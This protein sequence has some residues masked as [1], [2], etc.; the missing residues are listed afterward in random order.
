MNCEGDAADVLQAL[1]DQALFQGLRQVEESIGR[2]TTY[3]NGHQKVIEALSSFRNDLHVNCMVPIGKRALMRGK[4]IHTNEVLACL[5]AGYFAKYSASSAIALC[6]RRMQEA[7]RLLKCF[8]Q[9]RDLYELKVMIPRDGNVFEDC[10]G[11]KI[12]EHWNE[13]QVEEWKIKHRE[14]EK[15]YRQR[16][17][18]L[19]EERKTIE[20]EEDLFDRLDQ[21][22]IE[23]ELADELNRLEDERRTLYGEELDESESE[24][25]EEEIGNEDEPEEAREKENT[26]KPEDPAILEN[27]AREENGSKAKKRVSFV[28]SEGAQESELETPSGREETGDEEDSEDEILKIEFAHTEVGPVAKED[29]DSI[30]TPRDIYRI[31]S[32]PKSIL[33]RSPNDVP[34]VRV[35]SPEESSDDEETVK[36]STYEIVVKDIKERDTPS[37]DKL[38]TDTGRPISKFKQNRNMRLKK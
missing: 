25:S 17:A 30:E 13:R 9:E 8:E 2:L 37:V 34:P 7:E 20:T 28:E 29:G 15:E 6:E 22:E 3:K 12:V 10:A 11:R 19:R 31:F 24:S 14:R 18:K 23:E 5:G 36:P 21:L 32:K 16:A 35:P 26:V 4:M 38:P 27:P 1:R 33:K